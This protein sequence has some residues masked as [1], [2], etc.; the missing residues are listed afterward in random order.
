MTATEV[1]L[2][3]VVLP[4]FDGERFVGEAL[5]SVLAQTHE[6][7][8]VVVC[9]DGSSDGTVEI[10]RAIA[11]DDR[12]VRV[13]RNPAR[14]GPVG[15]FERCLELASAPFVKFLM[16]DD[17][18]VAHAIERLLAALRA[19]DDITLATSRRQR[20]DEHG[21]PLPDRPE[22]TV[23]VDAD[24]VM[25]GVVLG[26]LV[27]ERNL[28]LIGEPSTVLFRRAA[29]G[30]ARPFTLGG[31]PYRFLADV[32]LWLTLLSHGRAAYLTELLS[33][34]RAHPDQD[35]A[36]RANMVVSIL[37]WERL[38]RDG[39]AMGFLSSPDA[40]RCARE[41][42]LENAPF[43][44]RFCT[45][46]AQAGALA[47]RI[48]ANNR[49]AAHAGSRPRTRAVT[50]SA[51]AIASAPVAGLLAPP[52]HRLRRIRQPRTASTARRVASR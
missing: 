20:M 46:P 12:R 17:V 16:Q 50:S 25:D 9:D 34:S 42:W 37:E 6:H 10:V 14:L 52:V 4:T 51:R 41:Q 5:T 31:D 39:E 22:V 36:N 35:S 2:V 15:N 49:A 33:S 40:R 24:T 27:L 13:E 48:V 8:E 11:R 21:V 47:R 32:A 29:L 30:H 1:D 45:G 28:N 18:L 7:L 44:F 19:A 26:D 43:F 23:P 38:H 3:S